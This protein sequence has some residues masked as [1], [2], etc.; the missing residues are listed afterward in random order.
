MDRFTAQD[1]QRNPGP[2]QQAAGKT[3]VAITYRGRDR[4]VMMST[5]EYERLKRRD[6]QSFRIEDLPE[7]YVELLKEPYSNPE[8]DALNYLLD[9]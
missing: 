2:V 9:E 4:F 1:L 3:P 8:Q 5:D 7:E 6:R